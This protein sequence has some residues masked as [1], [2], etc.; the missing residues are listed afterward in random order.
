VRELNY[1]T[2]GK[3]EWRER[4]DPELHAGTD[5]LV[6]PFVAG[7]CDGDTLPIHH[8]GV[9]RAMQAGLKAGLIDAAVGHICGPV[10]FH[11]PVP[12]GH[13]AIGEVVALGPDV[14]NLAIGDKVVVPWSVSCGTC[15]NCQRGLT[16]KCSTTRKDGEAPNGE[17]TLSAFGFGPASGPYGGMVADLIR[18]P[19]ADQMLVKIPD[20]LEPLR[21]AAAS[22]NLSD[23]WRTVVPQL[24]ARPGATV[25]V[26]GGA[27]QSIGLYAAGLAV[28][29]G[30][31]VVDYLDRS[32]IRINI[33]ESFGASGHG[34]RRPRIPAPGRGYPTPSSAGYDIVVEASSSTPGL[35]HA[36]RSTAPGGVCTAVGY[37]F[38]TNSA[39]P[40]MH[41]YATDITLHLGV[42]HPRAVLPELLTWMS[43]HDFAA[44]NVT[45][46]LADFDDAPSAYAVRT[47]KLVLHRSPLH[48]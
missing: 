3:L 36:V 46:T 10:P 33:A 28:A 4:P 47:T 30:A 24:E 31:S 18:V 20:G 26:V 19:Y 12:M 7:R 14:E 17:R 42:S 9:S 32:S 21:V 40:L 44:E 6:R 8:R 2:T 34:W 38:G 11:G 35:R 37:Y 45:T 1:V 48:Q 43:S 15:D 5:A 22:D 41:M 23:A 13:E 27:A 16:S 25:L 39:V 29:H